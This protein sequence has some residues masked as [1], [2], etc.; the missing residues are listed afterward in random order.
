MITALRRRVA[1]DRGFSLVELAVYILVFGIL[2]TVITAVI[3][4]LFRSEKTVSGLT[5]TANDSQTLVTQLN[6]DVRNARAFAVRDG[7]HRVVASVAS[8]AAGAISWQCVNWVATGS[9]TNYRITRNGVALLDRTQ[10]NGTELFF[11]TAGPSE[12]SRGQSGTL[13]FTFR[14]ATSDE[15]LIDVFGSIGNVAQGTTA[16]LECP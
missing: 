7:G 15:G 11:S 3:I 1:G 16:P 13:T 4:T 12:I 9:G 5:N 10:P 2:M 8:S 6:R 14:A